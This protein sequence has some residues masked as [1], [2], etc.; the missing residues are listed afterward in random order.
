MFSFSLFLPFS[1]SEMILLHSLQFKGSIFDISWTKFFNFICQRVQV[2]KINFASTYWLDVQYVS[3][4]KRR[5]SMQCQLHWRY[6]KNSNNNNNKQYLLQCQ[7]KWNGKNPSHIFQR[8]WSWTF[9]FRFFRSR[10]LLLL[11]LLMCA[12][13]WWWWY[14]CYVDTVAAI[15]SLFSTIFPW[16]EFNDS[17]RD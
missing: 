2:I 17:W 8:Q 3:K 5:N 6:H 16:N 9:T 1:F 14:G 12:L 4:C 10:F 7:P 13:V 15:V 11:L